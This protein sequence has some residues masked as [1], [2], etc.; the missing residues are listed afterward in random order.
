MNNGCFLFRVKS[1]SGI[2]QILSIDPTLPI[3]QL[4]NKISELFSCP[5]DSFDLF[6][7]F[8]PQRVECCEDTI[9]QSILKSNSALLI[10]SKS[11]STA[12]GALSSTAPRPTPKS[13]SSSNSSGTTG[14]NNIRSLSS[15]VTSSG[16]V[17][18]RR[19]T[20]IS[21]SSQED[22]ADHLIA[23]VGGS[24]N[25]N[26]ATDKRSVVLRRV[27][28]SAVQRQYKTTLSTARQAAGLSGL[29]TLAE[30]A[31]VRVLGASSEV[32]RIVVSFKAGLTSRTQ[33]SETIDLIP[34]ELIK[35]VLEEALSDTAGHG[36][37][38]PML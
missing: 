11:S 9:I 25:G 15:P 31:N 32:R 34:K 16:L 21:A 17:A 38:V 36:R 27:F 4:K 7:G 28:K 5:V 14:G 24:D 30:S 20:K 19:R 8:P 33:H 18:S 1:P 12:I 23:A 26:T 37:Y 13:T 6:S 35:A 29:F 2:S 10:N 3:A 22:I